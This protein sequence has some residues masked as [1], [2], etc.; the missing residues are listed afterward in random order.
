MP[1]TITPVWTLLESFRGNPGAFTDD[2]NIPESG[3]GV[4]DLLDE[5]KW[6]LDFLLRCQLDDGSVINRVGTEKHPSSGSPETDTQPRRRTLST[7]WATATFAGNLA[8]A[9]E[10]FAGYDKQMPGY[11][12]KLRAAAERAW[13]YL[14][15]TPEMTPADGIDGAGGGMV[16]A[17]GNGDVH[18]DRRLR[19]YAAAHLFAATGSDVYRLYFDR[20]FREPA[21][22]A[23]GKPPELLDASNF[24]EVNYAYFT[25]ARSGGATPSVIDEVRRIILATADFIHGY[26]VRD[27]DGYRAFTWEGHYCWGSNHLKAQWGNLLLMPVRLGIS[28]GKHAGYRRAAAGYLHFIHG[29]NALNLNYLSNANSLG[30]DRSVMRPYHTW[31]NANVLSP[32]GYLVGGPN[33]F[34]DKKFNSP[35]FGQPP[36]KSYLDFQRTWNAEHQTTEDSWAITEPA[37]YYQG[38]YTLLLSEFVGKPR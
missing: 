10:V 32:P 34:Y 5:L 31:F 2:T 3:N 4:P 33:K 9:A 22:F 12:A 20:H 23:D 29:R 18:S 30:A 17:T 26:H 14:D 11:S 8:F 1:F 6:E 16:S 35:P 7:T 21:L 15:R 28:P 37:I 24:H 27:E 13:A 25:Y 36:A 19:L 38:A